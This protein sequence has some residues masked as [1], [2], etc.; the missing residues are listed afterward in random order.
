MSSTGQ[1]MA[2]E[3]RESSLA[4]DGAR[5][6]IESANARFMEAFGAGDA[7][8]VG[9]CYTRDA[10]LLPAN[11]D[12]I[13]GTDAITAF[14]KGAMGLGIATARLETAEVESFGNTA[15]E[16]GRYTLGAADG[17]PIDRGKYIVIWQRGSGEW[18]L[19]RDMWTTSMPVQGG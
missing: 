18:K 1:S 5:A 13:Q 15:V 6:E 7:A 17:A 8:G 16:V 14:W 3:A 11:S 10:Q 19:H 4:G 2:A 12:A 9:A